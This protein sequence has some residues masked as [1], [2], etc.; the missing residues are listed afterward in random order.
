MFLP[1]FTTILI[2]TLA[3]A[4]GGNPL[5]YLLA[6]RAQARREVKINEEQL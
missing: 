2:F 5:G 1:K 3:F 4:S 6:H